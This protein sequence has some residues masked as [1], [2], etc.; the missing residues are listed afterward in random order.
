KKKEPPK[1]DTTEVSEMEAVNRRIK[2]TPDDADLYHKRAEL[3]M[4]NAR[5]NKALSDINTAIE[6]GGRKADYIITLS[7]IY[8]AMGQ[9]TKTEQALQS[10]LIEDND[11]LDALLKMAQLHLYRGNHNQ[12]F[13]FLNRALSFAPGDERIYFISGMINK[14]KGD[15]DKAIRDFHRATEQ[16]QEFYDAFIQL[17]IIAAEQDDS[18]AVLYYENALDARP[19]SQEALYNLGFFYQD[20]ERYEKAIDTYNRLLD[21]NP[22]NINAYYNLGYINLTVMENYQKAEEY[23]SR[24]LDIDPQNVNAVYNL[25]YALE[26]QG[27]I[28]EARKHYRQT[29]EMEENFRLGIQGLNR[30]DQK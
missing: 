22:Q 3:H 26:L 14:D 10:V 12:A 5:I 19:E 11:H 7:D 24:V 30:L 17:G 25:G 9:V 4:E 18:L 23:F 28:E 16:D 27:D 21:V 20:Q 8:F 15:T 1:Q 29:L 2:A 13:S 6:K